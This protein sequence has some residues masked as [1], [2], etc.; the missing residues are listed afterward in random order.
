[1][2]GI[3]GLSRPFS[4]SQQLSPFENRLAE[5]GSGDFSQPSANTPLGGSRLLHDMAF[6]FPFSSLHADA[7]SFAFGVQNQGMVNAGNI[8]AIQASATPAESS[9]ELS[10]PAWVSRYPT[11]RSIDDLEAGFRSKVR[12]FIGSIE[13]AGGQVSISATR[14]PAERAYLMHYAWKIAN[15]TIQP[16][17]VPAR[18][19]VNINW[20]HGD[21]AK[22]KRAAQAMVNAYGIVHQPSL[23]SNHIDGIAIDMTISNMKGKTMKNGGGKSIKI[24]SNRGLHKVGASFGVHKLVSDPPPLV[25]QWPLA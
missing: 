9:R 12:N 2:T 21:A 17:E 18:E 19:G 5:P 13:A 6:S 24:N 11:S 10:G 4:P 8:E 23:T 3:T 22:S 15:G 7:T 1:M 16:S 20:D 25:S 14:R